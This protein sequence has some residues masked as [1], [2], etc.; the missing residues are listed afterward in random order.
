MLRSHSPDLIDQE[1]AGWIT[2]TELLGAALR[3]AA[4][5]AGS[6]AKGPRTGRPGLT[7]RRC[8]PRRNRGRWVGSAAEGDIMIATGDAALGIWSEDMCE[9][10]SRNSPNHD[11]PSGMGKLRAQLPSSEGST[12]ES[13]DTVFQRLATGQ[14]N[15]DD[16]ELLLA[17]LPP[18]LA[19]EI[20]QDDPLELTRVASPG[21][22]FR[23]QPEGRPPASQTP[24]PGPAF[25][26]GIQPQQG[27][28]PESYPR[29]SLLR[30]LLRRALRRRGSGG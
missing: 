19:E 30:R 13:F 23:A 8:H 1:H 20:R 22:P 9:R 15:S 3:S 4:A 28:Q 26:P 25:I 17:R 6:F 21:P 11:E 16:L 27:P 29:E 5:V 10:D 7:M 18:E 24:A 2:A 14:V 12:R